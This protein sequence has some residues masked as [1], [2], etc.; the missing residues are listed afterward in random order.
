MQSLGDSASMTEQMT[1]D[2]EGRQATLALTAGGSTDVFTN[3][4]CQ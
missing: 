3:H 4:Y 2:T 1:Y